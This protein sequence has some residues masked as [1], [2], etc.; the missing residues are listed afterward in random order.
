M[1]IHFAEFS[2]DLLLPTSRDRNDK[3]LEHAPDEVAFSG[4]SDG[5]PRRPSILKNPL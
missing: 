4:K 2:Y 1:V 3:D 5:L